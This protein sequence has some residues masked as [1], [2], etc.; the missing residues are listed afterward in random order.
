MLNIVQ[1]SGGRGTRSLTEAFLAQGNCKFVSIVNA[2][3]DGKS[4]GQIRRF[5][6]M[7]GPSD[8]RKTQQSM[9][10]RDHP[11]FDLHNSLFDYRFRDKSDH[12]DVVLQISRFVEGSAD[13]IGD[14]VVSRAD[15]AEALRI[16]GKAFLEGVRHAEIELGESF[17]FSDCSLINCFY[18][19]AFLV[20]QRDL[21]LTTNFFDKLFEIRGT[22]VTTNIENKKLVAIRESGEVLYSEAE[23]VEL[24]SNVR[25]KSLFI[26]DDYPSPNVV[27][28]M[29]AEER[30]AYL[31]SLRTSV[32]ADS[33]VL[34]EIAGADILIYGPGTQHSSLYPSY[35]AL[36]VADAIAQNRHAIKIFVCNI[37]EDYEI[38]EYTASE[39]VNGAHRYLLMESRFDLTK[40]KFFDVVLANQPAS[41]SPSRSKYVQNDATTE[42][43]G[44]AVISDNFEDADNVGKHD[45]KR[46]VELC[47]KLHRESLIH[48]IVKGLQ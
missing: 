17:D 12:D 41:P 13:G 46:V 24:R 3:D 32:T 25:I 19:G 11:D 42:G 28:P 8:I 38:P 2:Y 15:L 31:Q 35:L 30:L 47:L 26:V 7:L 23:I 45:G 34:R 18:A 21:A 6:K 37:G 5:F 29:T 14:I 27:E 1:F 20:F 16:F 43:L 10:S 48:R 36:G 39:L 4:S 9:L 22:V 44:I 33:A 40:D